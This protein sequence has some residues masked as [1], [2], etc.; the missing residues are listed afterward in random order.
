VPASARRTG[1]RQTHLTLTSLASHTH[2]HLWFPLDDALPPRPSPSPS[3]PPSPL[4]APSPQ[5]MML[6]GDAAA[7][8]TPLSPSGELGTVDIRDGRAHSNSSGWTMSAEVAKKSGGRGGTKWERKYSHQST[9]K[10]ALEQVGY[11]TFYFS[12]KAAA[13]ASLPAFIDALARAQAVSVRTPPHKAQPKARTPTTRGQTC[14]QRT[15]PQKRAASLV[16]PLN[17]PERG[18][19]SKKRSRAGRKKKGD[20]PTQDERCSALIARV[21]EE[22][23]FRER[24]IKYLSTYDT[25]DRAWRYVRR[26]SAATAA[27]RR[28]SSSTSLCSLVSCTAQCDGLALTYSCTHCRRTRIRQVRGQCSLC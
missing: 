3:L 15:P 10:T 28:A 27:A 19:S 14:A 8:D 13:L 4:I 2:G 6:G 9:V 7:A 21:E 12:T 24:A 22:Q 25:V 26:S 18:A 5:A 16:S 23:R 17:S 1:A 11:T 20:R